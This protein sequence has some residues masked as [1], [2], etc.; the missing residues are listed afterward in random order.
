MSGEHQHGA[1]EQHEAGSASPAAPR[2]DAAFW[3]ERYGS[4]PALWSGHV[5]E[6]VR[7]EVAQ[8]PPGRALDVGCGEGGDALWLAERGWQ[9]VGVDVSQVALD[10]AAARAH[11]TGLEARTTWEQRDLL[12]WEPPA[13]SYD[14]V[15][16]AFVHLGSADRR[17]VYA[18][19]AGAV[20][21]GGTFLVVAHHPSDLG[22]VPRPPHPE[23]FFT[24]EELADDLRRGPG[25][26][27][28]VTAE[29]R[30]RPGEHPEGYPVTLH[31]TVLRARRLG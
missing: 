29:A 14:L 31:D 10:R 27:Q 1:S 19:L 23:L 25:S 17:P 26:W 5:N 21:P 20:A 22:V 12:A 3:D 30:A 15:S 8:L 24:A 11:E 2:W 7:E 16:V 4:A 6:V 13:R 9:V 28:V 18:A